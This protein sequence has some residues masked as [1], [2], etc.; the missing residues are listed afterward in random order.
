M[1]CVKNTQTGEVRRVTEVE[2]HVLTKDGK[3][4]YIPKSVW[5][6]AKGGK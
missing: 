4:K 2:A 1:K 6:K 3:W 5:R